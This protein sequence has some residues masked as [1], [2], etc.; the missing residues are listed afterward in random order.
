MT[1][2]KDLGPLLKRL[3]LGRMLPTLPERVALAR[4]DQLDY[5]SFL[6]VILS[7]EVAR[8]DGNR[9][10]NRIQ[11]AGFEQVCRLEDFDWEADINLDRRLIDAVFSLEFIEAREHVLLVGPV[12]VG[13][14]FLAQ[15]LGYAALK[16]D[17]SVRFARADDYFRDLSHA[18]NRVK[19]QVS[20]SEVGEGPGRG[21]GGTVPPSRT[22]PT[23]STA[24]PN[25]A[26]GATRSGPSSHPTRFDILRPPQGV[27]SPGTL[28][29]RR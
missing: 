24:G 11:K 23:R 9:F 15:A 25:S 10:R 6:E 22:Y 27:A 3:K 7:D 26:A 5:L 4:R 12:G 29:R 13:K 19:S 20:G 17:R 2:A 1:Q 8:R 14:S 16:A 18:S 21:R 28:R